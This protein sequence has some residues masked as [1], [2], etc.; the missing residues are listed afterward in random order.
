[1]RRLIT[2]LAVALLAVLIPLSPAAAGAFVPVFTVDGQKSVT[3]TAGDAVDL[4][5]EAF[6]PGDSTIDL[7]SAPDVA[8]WDESGVEDQ[9]TRTVTLTDPGTYTFTVNVNIDDQGNSGLDTEEVSVVVLPAA[10]TVVDPEPITFP[11]TCTVLIPRQQGVAYGYGTGASGG[12]LDPGSYDLT[13][14][15]T[16]L[17]FNAFPDP[18]YAFPDGTDTVVNVTTPDSCFGTSA[19]DDDDDDAM[20]P[21]VAPA[22]GI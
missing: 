16:T 1:M 13:D 12:A 21:S 11:D 6:S 2:V 5:W 8:A 4:A 18:G 9:G 7:T 22:A 3:I 10:A 15:G 19:G 14:L 20:H 17:T